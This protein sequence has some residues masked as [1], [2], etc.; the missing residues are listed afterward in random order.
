MTFLK[1]VTMNQKYRDI[2]SSEEELTTELA[3]E[4][5][6]STK[7]VADFLKNPKN[8]DEMNEPIEEFETLLQDHMLLLRDLVRRCVAHKATLE[9]NRSF[10]KSGFDVIFEELLKIPLEDE[11]LS[12]YK[13]FDTN[14]DSNNKNNLL[15]ATSILSLLPCKKSEIKVT[16]ATINDFL[17]FWNICFRGKWGKIEEYLKGDLLYIDL[18]VDN[19]DEYALNNNNNNRFQ[20]T[21]RYWQSHSMISSRGCFPFGE[22]HIW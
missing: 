5:V 17:P 4:L 19:S 22:I 18:E 9:K 3:Q 10:I 6:Q 21:K 12:D 14:F 20:D 7:T 1:E 13:F 8:R 2:I 16:S 11:L 15:G